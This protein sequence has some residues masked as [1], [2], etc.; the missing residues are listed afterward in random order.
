MFRKVVPVLI[1]S[2]A[3]AWTFGP[4]APQAEQPELTKL[5]RSPS[6]SAQQTKAEAKSARDR[7]CT[8]VAVNGS[9]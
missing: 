4:A 1:L 5:L 2:V 6:I 3:I 9:Q 8:A 7:E